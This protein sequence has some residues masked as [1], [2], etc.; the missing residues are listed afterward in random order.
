MVYHGVPGAHFDLRK[1]RGTGGTN[2]S[3]SVVAGQIYS[4]QAAG[5]LY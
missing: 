1:W 3:L 4:S 5:Q 2:Y